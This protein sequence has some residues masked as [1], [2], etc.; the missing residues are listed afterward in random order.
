MPA[1]GHVDGCILL[2]RRLAMAA[3]KQKKESVADHVVIVV[4]RRGLNV[5]TDFFGPFTKAKAHVFASHHQRFEGDECTV[6]EMETPCQHNQWIFE[7]V[8]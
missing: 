2:N 6:E 4:K 5:F 7:G 3:T 1:V 8:E